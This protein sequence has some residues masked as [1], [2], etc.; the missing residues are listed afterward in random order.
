MEEQLSGYHVHQ[1][2][3][4]ENTASP[5]LGHSHQC[6]AAA[7]QG[8]NSTTKALECRRVTH[9]ESCCLSVYLQHPVT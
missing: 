2:G 5:H 7:A 1:E 8:L 3:R 9:T 6:P 4:L